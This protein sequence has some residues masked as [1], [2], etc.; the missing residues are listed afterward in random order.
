MR[1]IALGMAVAASA[2]AAPAAARDGQAYFGA[3]LGVVVDNSFDVGIAGTPDV[4][5]I[6]NDQSWALGAFLGYDFGMIR[7]EVEIAYRETVPDT[8]VA[9]APGHP[10][11]SAS[12]VACMLNTDA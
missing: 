3:D 2:L 6:E 1:K 7:T 8:I 9:V 4:A 11:F 12:S 10:T 5:N